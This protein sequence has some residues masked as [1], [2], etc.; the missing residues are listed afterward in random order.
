MCC[1][2]RDPPPNITQPGIPWPGCPE[3]CFMTFAPPGSA[4]AACFGAIG[5]T[6]VCQIDEHCDLDYG[7]GMFSMDQYVK[8][9]VP[10]TG[11]PSDAVYFGHGGQDYASGSGGICGFNPK[12]KF[13]FCVNYNSYS[14]APFQLIALFRSDL[15]AESF[16]WQE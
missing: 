10:G 9:V 3:K 5:C 4:A 11:D 14:G 12:Y 8:T 7:L 15:D 1:G 13:G 16:S 6:S 2:C